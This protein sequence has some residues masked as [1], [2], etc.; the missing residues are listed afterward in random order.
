M[1][2]RGLW[3]DLVLWWEAKRI[4]HLCFHNLANGQGR[5]TCK[6]IISQFW[7]QG[8]QRSHIQVLFEYQWPG[9]ETGHG[10]ESHS[11]WW[12]PESARPW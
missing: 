12:V 8:P 1:E 11:E 5:V 3:H 10:S 2:V 9:E 4:L 7:S 6:I